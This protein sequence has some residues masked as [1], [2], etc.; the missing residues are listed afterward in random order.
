M[1]LFMFALVRVALICL[2]T[3]FI[4]SASADTPDFF[5]LRFPDTV[6]GFT[7]GKVTDF[8]KDHPGL[9][10]GVKYSDKGW[11]IDIFIYDDGIANIPDSLSAET[12]VAQFNQAQNDIIEQRRKRNENVDI[13]GR[14]DI[15][16]PDSKARFICGAYLIATSDRQQLDSFLCLTT[17]HG[18]FVKYRLS[19]RSADGT[20]AVAKR[21]VSAW[22]T[23]LRP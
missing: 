1:G 14:F 11:A 12:V 8:E 18:K 19:T 13:N 7:R 20:T 22:I 5:G 6:A 2:F 15:A 16:G 4:T 9:G 21:F 10:Y 17:W 23:A 3:I